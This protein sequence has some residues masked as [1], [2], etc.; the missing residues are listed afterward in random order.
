LIISRYL[1]RE[2]LYT[3]LALSTLLVLIYISN[4][5]IAYLVQ[6]SVGD[7][8]V[9]FIFQLLALKL[10]SGLMLILPLSLFL[11]ILLS[12]GRLYKD[13]EITAMAACGIPMPTGSIISFGA[14]FAI[15]VSLLT[16]LVAPWAERQIALLQS[17]LSTVAAEVSGVAAGRFKGFYQGKGIFYVEGV[18]S[19]KNTM[20]NLFMQ[21]KLPKKQIIMT[22]KSGYKKAQDGELFLVLVDGYR[23]ESPPSSLNYVVTKF[24][25]HKIRIPKLVDVVKSEETEAIPTEKLWFADKPA[26]QAELQWRLAIPL[27]VI[28]LAALAIPLSHTNPRQGQYSKIFAGIII[29]LIYGNL[30]NIAK[31][32][33]ERGDVPAWIGIWWVHIGLLIIILYLFYLPFLKTQARKFLKS[34]QRQKEIFNQVQ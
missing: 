34:R 6:A 31:K 23:Y 22:A 13:N 5:F 1:Y 30:M 3:L 12:L 8:P 9:A 16:L 29:Y 26:L 19:E 21:T 18:D 28:L 14:M 11:A 24:A 32:W 27:S 17:N 4:R 25:E 10:L 33:L 15:I 7:L 20:Q 2:I